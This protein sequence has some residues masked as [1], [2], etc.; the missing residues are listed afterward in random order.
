M[1]LYQIY[2]SCF[3]EG[4]TGGIL[5]HDKKFNQDEFDAMVQQS[6]KNTGGYTTMLDDIEDDLI[7]TFGFKRAEYISSET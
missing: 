6:L 3:N 5:I 1:Y 2:W 7:A 4:E